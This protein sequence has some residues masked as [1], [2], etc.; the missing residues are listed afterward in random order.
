[1]SEK[2]EPTEHQ[3]KVLGFR[4]VVNILSAG[5]RGSGKTFG[6]MMGVLAQLEKYPDARPLVVRETWLALQEIQRELYELCV[7]AFG[8]ASRNQQAGTIEVA[9]GGII[10]LANIS[11]EMSYARFQGRSFTGLF[12]DEVGNYTPSG[13]AFLQRV[14][15]N[16]RGPVGMRPE[17]HFTANPHGRSHALLVKQFMSKSP[18]WHPFMHQDGTN[19]LWTTGNLYDNPNIDADEYIRNLKASTSGDA[20][21]AAAWISGTW[22]TLA[23]AMFSSFNPEVHNIPKPINARYVFRCGGDWGSAAPAA[24]ILLGQIDNDHRLPDGRIIPYGSVI[25]L[26]ETDTCPDG[27]NLAVGNG[28]PPQM[29]AEQV[30]DMC[31]KHAGKK[32]EIIM[33]DARGLQS[34]T[35]IDLFRLNGL[36][37]RKPWKKD[38]VGQ[39]ALINQLL[40]NSITGEGPGLFFVASECPRICE[41]LPEAPRGQLRAE[42]IDPKWGV[43]HWLDALAYGLRDIWGHRATQGTHVGMY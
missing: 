20:A 14:R 32:V 17:C 6:L 25:A 31:N 1:M 41:T 10:T 8:H 30:M 18:P 29:F 42:D 15:S 39:W 2:I 27:N 19:W 9:T 36:P 37:A 38:R 33:D 26:A 43:D 21:L 24:A 7:Q 28:A 40:E 4:D 5:G 11:D 35:V 22:A 16:L 34:D 23:G 3:K 12:A 13:W